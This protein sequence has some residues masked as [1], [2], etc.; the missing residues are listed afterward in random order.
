[1]VWELV[2]VNNFYNESWNMLFLFFQIKKVFCSIFLSK[3]LF[4]IAK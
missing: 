4:S 1:M 2:I 3:C